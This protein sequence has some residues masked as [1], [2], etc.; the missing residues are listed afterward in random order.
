MFNE[1]EKKVI[2]TGK[3]INILKECFRDKL[4]YE[5]EYPHKIELTFENTRKKVEEAH[6]WA[7]GKLLDYL[8][9]DQQLFEFLNSIHSFFLIGNSDYVN[10]FIEQTHAEFDNSARSLDVKRL[11]NLLQMCI[12]YSTV[13]ND[14]YRED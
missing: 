8:V 11:N 4:D 5:I 6:D 14:H 13:C 3:F 9:K 2:N 12:S 10:S 1:I 7:N